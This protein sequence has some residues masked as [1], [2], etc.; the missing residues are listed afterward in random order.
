MMVHA[1]QGRPEALPPPQGATPSCITHH[2]S[3]WCC[4]RVLTQHE[5][6]AGCIHRKAAEAPTP[7][8][9]QCM[10][11]AHGPDESDTYPQ[12]VGHSR[13]LGER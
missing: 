5:T 9:A 6:A 1:R 12:R 4:R 3:S 11:P 2:V 7:L 8:H 10:I 13:H